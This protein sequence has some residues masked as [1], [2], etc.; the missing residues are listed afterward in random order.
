MNLDLKI[1]VTSNTEVI[2]KSKKIILPITGLLTI[3]GGAFWVWYSLGNIS[4]GAGLD[5]KIFQSIA[6]LYIENLSNDSKDENICA[7]L[8]KFNIERH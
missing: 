1:I 3:I 4:H 2:K 8:T 6:V 5:N 7:G